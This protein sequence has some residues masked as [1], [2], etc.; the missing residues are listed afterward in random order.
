MPGGDRTGPMGMGP[1]TGRGAGYCRGNAMPGYANRWGDWGAGRGFGM[2]RGGGRGSGFGRGGYGR[3]RRNR[4]FATGVPG[5]AWDRGAV[6]PSATVSSRVA[7]TR[8]QERRYL[9]QQA[10]SL[11]AELE[12]LNSRLAQLKT[13]KET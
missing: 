8:E 9:E 5:W 7:G 12:E 11:R 2:G 1:A 6:D 4:F 13:D 3:G 10:E